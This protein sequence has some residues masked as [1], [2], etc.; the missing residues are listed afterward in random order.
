M[1]NSIQ[2]IEDADCILVIGSNTSVAHPLVATRVFRAKAKGA[3]LIVCDPR[4][5]HLASIADLYVR[6][7]L[8][9]DVALLNGIM[10]VILDR[11]W[12]NEAFIRERT[13]GFEDLAKILDSYSPEYVSR[14]TD[15]SPDDI[16]RMAEWYACSEK[17]TILYT[18]GITQHVTGVDN[19]KTLA[20]LAMMTGQIGREST[21]VNPLRGQ[22]NVQG[23][24]DMG[25]LPNVYPGY[26]PVT[27]EDVR[28]KFEQAWGVLNL[29]PGVGLTI[30]EMM[31]AIDEGK[32]R[33]LVIM[34]ENP[35]LSDPD[36]HHVEEMLRKLDF[37][38]VMDIF[39][40]QT[41]ELAHVVL[42][43]AA[44]AEKDGTFANTERR[45]QRVRQAVEPPGE[46]RPDWRIIQELSTR[47]GYPMSYAS[48]SEIQDEIA[49][50]TPSYGGIVY[51]RLE[52]EG[53]CWPCPT[54]D[55]P[56]TRYLHKD[57]FVRGKGLFHAVSYRAPAEEPDAEYP[58][59]LSTGRVYAHYHT[60]T[61]TR[62]S[63]SLHRE[64]PE[65]FMELNP[66]D[67]EKL[68]LRD[69]DSARLVS[70]RGAI[71]ALVYITSRVDQGTVFMPFHFAEA[72]A[73]MLTNTAYD[74]IAKIPELKVCA[75]RLEKAA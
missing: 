12:H 56:G 36:S 34:G 23:A 4:K 37:L 29:N 10:H 66:S 72:A 7:R 22:N 13:E 9:S 42:P 17:S 54:L 51:S 65:G 19:V 14:I 47:F 62:N 3:K 15:V 68:G 75:V 70:R 52:G 61:M 60:G 27:S 33:A 63:P 11:G 38:L 43:G 41:A 26:Q 71:T 58:M 74:P 6:H 40:T 48:A 45:V 28:R 64:M 18:M 5:I 46:A 49:R 50:L 30:T 55:H 31:P 69:G 32:V 8:G 57:R 44:F 35:V 21:G 67:A 73:N 16:V 59:W 20:N 39:M 24:C 53:L 1:T 25:G 2:E